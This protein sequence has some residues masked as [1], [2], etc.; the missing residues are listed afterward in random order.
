MENEID[1]YIIRYVNYESDED[2]DY[3]IDNY[4]Q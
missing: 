3:D 4:D 2:D 1:E